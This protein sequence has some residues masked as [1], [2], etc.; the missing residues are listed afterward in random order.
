[1]TAA[2]ATELKPV[3]VIGWGNPG[4][5]DDGLGPAL[6]ER[7]E[8]AAPAG[9]TVD[10]GYQLMIEDAAGVAG[11]QV[12][13]FADASTSC[14]EPFRFRAAQPRAETGFSTHSVSPEAVLHLAAQCF[15]C[16]PRGY[17]LEIRGYEFEGFGEGLSPRAERNLAAAAGFL[18]E[19]L[20]S[21]DFEAAARG[22]SP[23]AETQAAR[24]R[25]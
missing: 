15:G 21:G 20:R 6:A 11:H 25:T 12:T 1:L 3:L 7:L 24:A 2:G 8:A 4:R 16:R 22:P 14:P 18:A 5:R 13:V 23:A 10:S 19:R 17:V 9:V